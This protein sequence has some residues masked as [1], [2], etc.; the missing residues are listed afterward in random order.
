MRIQSSFNVSFYH[1]R[2]DLRSYPRCPCWYYR[3]K[4]PTDLWRWARPGPAYS[5]RTYFKNGI[6]NC[7]IACSIRWL[8]PWCHQG[9]EMGFVYIFRYPLADGLPCNVSTAIIQYTQ[10]ILAN[11]T[12]RTHKHPFSSS[13]FWGMTSRTDGQWRRPSAAPCPISLYCARVR[14]Q[15]LLKGVMKACLAS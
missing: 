1:S 5:Y 13:I 4:G 3:A 6:S 7:F 8:S 2:V 12:G 10:R 15:R 9:R 14:E 11:R